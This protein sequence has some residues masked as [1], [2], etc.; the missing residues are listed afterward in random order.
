MHDPFDPFMIDRLIQSPV[1]FM[2]NL[3]APIGSVGC[4]I[5]QP[6]F[7][8]K[9]F[10]FHGAD[11]WCASAPCVIAAFR[12]LKPLRHLCNPVFGTVVFHVKITDH[13]RFFAKKALAFFRNSFSSSSS[14][15][16]FFIARSSASSDGDCRFLQRAGRDAP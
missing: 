7:F 9:C 14:R 15:M 5:N 4:F 2:G 16:R 11:G 1:Y 8:Q 12:Y 13:F 3:F 6:D 10:I